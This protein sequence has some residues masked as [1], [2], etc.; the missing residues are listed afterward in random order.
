MKQAK[1]YKILLT[2]VAVLM[3][4]LAGVTMLMPAKNTV[5]AEET[6]SA[7]IYFE[8]TSSID[9]DGLATVK[10]DG[11]T[12]KLKNAMVA[13]ALEIDATVADINKVEISFTT[14]SYDVN[15]NKDGT[16]YL[17]N[18][19]HKLAI[20]LG[21]AFTFNGETSA[22][23][24]DGNQLN[25]KFKVVNNVIS[26]SV[27]DGEFVSSAKS[28]Y[29]VEQYAVCEIN[30][31]TFT[32]TLATGKTQGTFKISSVN[33]DYND[34][35]DAYL[36]KFE[37]EN[38]EVKQSAL[39]KVS[40]GSTMFVNTQTGYKAIVYKYEQ[41][42]LDLKAYSV[43]QPIDASDL[44][45][46][47][48]NEGDRIKLSNEDKPKTVIFAEDNT[49]GVKCK[50]FDTIVDKI[51]VQLEDINNV[52]SENKAPEYVI[53][54]DALDSF[55]AALLKATKTTYTG[56]DKETYIR[57]GDKV[58]VPSMESLVIDDFTAYEKLSHTLYYSTPG[59][60]SLST[61]TGW[62]IT[63]DLPGT[64]TFYVVF[65]DAQG[66]SMNKEDIYKVNENDANLLDDTKYKAFIFTFEIKDD[67]EI[68]VTAIS[69]HSNGFLNTK[70]TVSNFIIDGNTSEPEYQLW[71]NKDSNATVNKLEGAGWVQIPEYSKV[72]NGGDLPKGF[73]LEQ[74]KKT[75]YTGELSFTPVKVGK[76]VIKCT[77]DS[78]TSIDRDA[79]SAYASVVVE[80]APKVVT[81]ANDWLGDNVSSVIFLSIGAACLIGIIALLFVK[82]KA[83][84]QTKSKK[85]K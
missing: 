33:Q 12:F 66:E 1:I 29:K 47:K 42:K 69:N 74:I 80:K 70:Y 15:G 35:T 19:E 24:V 32:F 40:L 31:L 34:A 7:P 28:L 64:Y 71:Y 73:T 60:R 20:E 39:P 85:Q 36:Q 30:S 17:D 5:Y 58:T 79:K 83:K 11:Q 23:V 76:Y 26:V 84:G 22:Y 61:T 45:L 46:A 37:F 48:V 21:K 25:V 3:F 41:Y 57:L 9:K 59:T 78:K 53:N 44:Y 68:K 4:V 51:T 56:S 49:V 43:L 52:S 14:G 81:P 6:T 10:A 82:P 77:V 18:I 62:E 75:N 67:A 2:A 65:K 38:G 13:D 72:K 63:T 54:Q 8:G 55:K 50:G 16:S 27:N